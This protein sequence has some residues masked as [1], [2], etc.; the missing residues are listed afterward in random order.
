MYLMSSRRGTDVVSCWNHRCC[1]SDVGILWAG[2][3]YHRLWMTWWGISSD[4]NSLYWLWFTLFDCTLWSSWLTAEHFGRAGVELETWHCGSAAWLLLCSH[5]FQ[6]MSPGQQSSTSTEDV[7][8]WICTMEGCPSLY[9]QC[10]IM[11]CCFTLSL[12]TKPR[13]IRIKLAFGI[14]V[15]RSSHFNLKCSLRGIPASVILFYFFKYLSSDPLLVSHKKYQI[16]D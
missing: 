1:V 5:R 8:D 10:M 11:R 14:Y 6:M 2:T 4:E 15:T 7:L 13:E 16:F 9:L 3:G 12:T